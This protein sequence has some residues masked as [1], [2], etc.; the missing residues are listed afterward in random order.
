MNRIYLTALLIVLSFN[1]SCKYKCS[2]PA[3][4]I[5]FQGF[6]NVELSDIVLEQYAS[7][8]AFTGTPST[9]IADTSAAG[10]RNGIT[11]LSEYDLERTVN[12]G[13]DW[14]IRIPNANKIFTLRD[15]K[16]K[17]KKQKRSFP[18]AEIEVCSNDLSCYINDK[19]F[20]FHGDSEKTVALILNK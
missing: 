8:G 14:I 2:D 3:I 16:I 6:S 7:D 12:I 17:Q 11:Y 10:T 4:I 9:Y 5:S 19:L 15:F 18:P 20:T 13:S 1:I